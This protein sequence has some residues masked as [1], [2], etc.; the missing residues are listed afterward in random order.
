MRTK[1]AAVVVL[2]AMSAALAAE[3]AKKLE[4]SAEPCAENDTG[5]VT[6]GGKDVL[7]FVCVFGK[8]RMYGNEPAAAPQAKAPE[9]APTPVAGVPMQVPGK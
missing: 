4:L 2:L 1:I 7:K 8:W 5:T 6:M 3:P 9:R